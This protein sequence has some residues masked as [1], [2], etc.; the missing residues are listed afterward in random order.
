MNKMYLMSAEG[1]KNGRVNFLRVQKTI[2]IWASMKDIGSGMNVKNISDLV[3]K[4]KTLQ[5]Y[6]LTNIK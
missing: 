2:E 6:K 3:L 4:Q 1:Y 5:K